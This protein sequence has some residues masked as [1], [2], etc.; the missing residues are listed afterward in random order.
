MEKP[1]RNVLGIYKLNQ[2]ELFK[3]VESDDFKGMIGYTSALCDPIRSHLLINIEH[4][5][6]ETG[7]TCYRNTVAH[8]KK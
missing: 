6:N 8:G 2:L 7:K 4:R 1:F 3:N 5:I